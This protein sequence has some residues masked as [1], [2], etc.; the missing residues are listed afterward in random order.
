MNSHTKRILL[1]AGGVL[2]VS[3]TGTCIYWLKNKDSDEAEIDFSSDVPCFEKQDASSSTVAKTCKEGGRG[4]TDIKKSSLVSNEV[5]KKGETNFQLDDLLDTALNDFLEKPTVPN[6][7][8]E[9]KSIG[10]ILSGT[11]ASKD[12]SSVRS[13][14]GMESV[15][16]PKYGLQFKI[17]EGW[18]ALEGP[19]NAPNAAAIQIAPPE[20]GA[21]G[22]GPSQASMITIGIEDIGHPNLPEKEI[23]ELLKTTSMN[24]LFLMTNGIQPVLQKDEPISVGPFSHMFQIMIASPIM[25]ICSTSFIALSNGIAYALQM[26]GTPN[27]QEGDIME[28]VAKTFIV[29]PITGE[30][31]HLEVTLQNIS[32]SVNPLWNLKADS[33]TFPDKALGAFEIKSKM[34]SEDAV[35]YSLGDEPEEFQRLEVKQCTDGVEVSCSEQMNKKRFSFNNFAICITASEGLSR[36][37]E[38]FVIEALKSIRPLESGLIENT[39]EFVKHSHYRFKVRLGGSIMESKLSLDTVVYFPKGLLADPEEDVLSFPNVIIRVDLELECE[40]LEEWRAK[41][42]ESTPESTFRKDTVCGQECL[43]VESTAMVETGINEK[44]EVCSRSLVFVVGSTSYLIRW[45]LATGAWKKYEQEFE[46]FIGG[47]HFMK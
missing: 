5:E 4:Q 24:T 17:P 30:L 11:P 46:R 16:F 26:I 9:E 27:S 8:E 35:L 29:E 21:P 6:H 47:F 3:V 40:T 10:K 28:K 7:Q 38:K 2:A 39:V 32:L 41:I 22:G 20:T 31:G 33:S 37:P 14:Q 45:E 42:E 34:A 13:L 43:I 25:A 44:T 1:I 36:V 23:I 19:T 12:L 18:V 15:H